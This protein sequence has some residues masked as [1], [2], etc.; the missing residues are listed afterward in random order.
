MNDKYKLGT[1]IKSWMDGQAYD[2]TFIVTEDCNLRCKYCYEIHKN[3]KKSMPFSVAKKAVDYI[4]E[5]SNIFKSQAVIWNFIGGEPLLEIDVIDK[6]ADYIK[7]KT[8]KENHPW[9]YMY[10]FC[11]ST[12]G[13]LYNNDKVQQFLKKNPNKVSI[14]ISI[15]GTKTKHDL[16]RVYKDGHGSYDDVVKNI[17]LWL[18]QFP[19][20][21]QTKVT[22]GSSDLKYVKDSIIHLWNLGIKDVPANVVFEDVWKD[23]DDLIFEEQLKQLADYIIDNK[24]WNY[25]NTS[26]FDESIGRPYNKEDLNR[27]NCGAGLMLSIDPYGNLYPC[28]RYSDF[29]MENNEGYTIGN[30]NDG[31]DF[32]KVRPFIGVTTKTQSDNECIDCEIAKGCGWCQGFNYDSSEIPTNY[33][34]A[35]FICKMHKARCRANDYYW[36]KLRETFAI[37]RNHKLDKRNYLFFIMDD[38]CVEYCDYDSMKI[39]RKMP[40]DIIKNGIKFCEDNFYMPIILHS[41]N[42]D[43][44]MDI[45]DFSYIN[46]IEIYE[47][48]TTIRN[49]NC[50]KIQVID[51]ENIAFNLNSNSNIDI[52]IL[53]VSQFKLDTLHTLVEKAFKNYY[54][55]N[56]N[57]KIKSK[58]IDYKLYRGELEKVSDIILDYYRNGQPKEFNKLTDII[59]LDLMDNCNAGSHTFALAP[60]GKIYVCPK[61]YFDN[62]QSY[63]GD[64]E[65]GVNIKEPNLFKL[66]SAPICKGC[67]MF[68]CNRCIYLNKKLTNEFNTPSSM[69]CKLSMIEKSIAV[70]LLNKINPNSY[71]LEHYNKLHDSNINDPIQKLFATKNINPYNIKA[72][73]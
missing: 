10:R 7:M 25:Y 49:N 34:R 31:I 8:F 45:N 3:N 52:C 37:E 71:T 68:N 60:N 33:K 61:F 17:P 53:N 39:S 36:D 22:I 73:L 26:L 18:S 20:N 35:K 50:K 72:F 57:L 51:E 27:N 64:L 5:N 9:A 42:N 38:N 70:S 29:C 16:Q 55:I 63:I 65:N 24:L 12:N 15:D 62:K 40:V 67:D 2:I 69:Q 19:N 6:I 56:L 1:Q 30:I 4:I 46:R 54:R 58:D 21:A 13:I 28:L 14:G 48:N 59:L 47:N 23:G 66:D 32:D 11:I 41:K 44:I 43:N